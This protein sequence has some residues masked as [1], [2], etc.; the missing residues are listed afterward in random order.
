MTNPE[1]LRP[2]AVLIGYARVFAVAQDFQEQVN[3]LNRLGVD[4]ARIYIDSGF[5]GEAMTRDGLAR[6]LGACRSGVTFVV[7]SIDRLASNALGVVDIV[8]D[9][10]ERGVILSVGGELYDPLDPMAAMFY[11]MLTAVAEAESG[12][13]S[14]RTREAMARPGVREKLQGRRPRLSPAQD[15]ELAAQFT[16]PKVDVLAI[17]AQFGISRSS[18]YRVRDRHRKRESATPIVEPT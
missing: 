18:V 6:A 16:D 14:L 4:P 9:L 11:R 8:K 15:A 12:W 5:S 7:P 17:A 10:G 3:S 1:E 2:E 13:N